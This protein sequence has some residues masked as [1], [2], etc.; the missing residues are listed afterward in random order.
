MNEYTYFR[1]YT[2]FYKLRFV[3][4]GLFV[5]VIFFALSIL[6][7]V[8]VDHRVQGGSQNSNSSPSIGMSSSPNAVTSG[9]VSMASEAGE[10]LEY[11]AISVDNGL[12]SARAAMAQAGKSVARGTLAGVTAV[13]RAT[14]KG[15][16]FV[17]HGVASG[18]GFVGRTV[19]AGAS[20]VFGAPG[21][22]LG[23]ASDT[24]MMNAV[25]RPGEMEQEEVPIID[26]ESPELLAALAALPAGETG[27][28]NSKKSGPAWPIHGDITTAFGVPHR[29]YQNTHT[30]ID[31]SDHAR[32]GVTPVRPF[33][34]GK[35]IDAIYSR[36][37]FGNHVIVDHGNGVT[38][39]YAHLSSIKVKVG[40]K[41]NLDTTLGYEGSTGLS[42]GVHLHFEIR[43]N[44]QAANPMQFISGRP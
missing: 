33:R 19:G 13:V 35:V 38:S 12:Q 5:V 41:V 3:F 9:L 30:G 34:P 1:L 42:T 36:Y 17:G 16:A 27:Q 6:L 26:P 15:L 43:V 31:I 14:G 2:F 25:L 4:A 20:F 11:T 8:V 21:R 18:F 10:A 39:L 22:V 37:G 7:S 32:A 28:S 29:P 40:Q 44:G 24:E 23:A